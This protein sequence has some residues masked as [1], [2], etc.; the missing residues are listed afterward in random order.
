MT[1]YAA[2]REGS[3]REHVPRVAGA[4]CTSR[5]PAERERPQADPADPRSHQPWPTGGPRQFPDTGPLRPSPP[6]GR[7]DPNRHWAQGRRRAHRASPMPALLTVFP[8]SGPTRPQMHGM[9]CPAGQM[10]RPLPLS[11]TSCR[12]L[13]RRGEDGTVGTFRVWSRVRSTSRCPA[14]RERPT[15]GAGRH[16]AQGGSRAERGRRVPPAAPG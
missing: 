2:R 11:G 14:E 15:T 10:R 7:S 5:W 1:I 6:S 12:F 16:R 4:R 3:G 13:P 8:L 9:T